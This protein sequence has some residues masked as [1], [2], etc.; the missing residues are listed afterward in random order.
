MIKNK[1][2]AKN[3]IYIDTSVDENVM[4]GLTN[5]LELVRN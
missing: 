4:V 2:Q 1:Y 3:V 5:V